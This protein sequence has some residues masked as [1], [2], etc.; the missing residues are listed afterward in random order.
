MNITPP[1][2]ASE[3]EKEIR[4]LYRERNE[5]ASNKNPSGS[6]SHIGRRWLDFLSL[7]FLIAAV[8]VASSIVVYNWLLPLSP[9]AISPG[10]VH[11]TIAQ[12]EL[13]DDFI[14]LLTGSSATVFATRVTKDGAGLIDQSYLNNDAL[15]QA[16]VLS[17][18]GWLVTTQLVVDKASGN[19]VVVPADGKAYPVQVVALDPVVPL[20]YLKISARNLT[21]TPF[22]VT[23]DLSINDPVIA[24]SNESQGVAK[25]WYLRYLS[26]LSVRTA[27][28]NRTD[29]VVSSESLP[30]R[31]I[32][33]QAVPSSSRGAPVINLQG[34][35]VGLMA[36]W[37]GQMRGVVPLVN[38][39]AVI[40]KLFSEQKAVR[41]S[42]GVNYIQSNWLITSEPQGSQ[43]A[44]LISQAKR[45]GVVAGS[46]AAKAGLKEG[47]KIIALDN[48]RLGNFSLS[49]VLQ[50]YRNGA[51]VEITFERAGK[52]QKA[53]ATLGAVEGEVFNSNTEE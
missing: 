43:G 14:K 9:S 11:T 5:K 50:R 26:N 46:S 7:L 20:A 10:S 44:I 40:D 1:P 34:K 36:D 12:P 13:S 23:S 17:S 37:G 8:G 33:D 41:P 25:S 39:T 42:L 49:L 35:V 45:A 19:Y 22:A 47:D 18:D 27:V 3:Y 16:L 24:I 2:P 52:E 53:N 32:L 38:M 6:S 15:G 28:A 31:Y 29:L 30:D 48:E 4:A 21:A 51:S